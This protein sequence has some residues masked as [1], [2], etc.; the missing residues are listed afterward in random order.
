MIHIDYPIML[1]HIA[2]FF[3][4]GVQENVVPA[5][6][7]LTF[8]VRL[9]V[10]TDHKETEEMIQ[11]FAEEAGPG[12]SVKYNIKEKKSPVTPI[13]SSNPWWV[14]FKEASDKM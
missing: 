7:T 2:T 4:G 9:S 13:D 8:D 3:Q 14:A 6:I 11:A 5:E 12:V 10:D 1:L